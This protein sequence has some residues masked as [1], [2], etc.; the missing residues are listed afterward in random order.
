M[1]ES[2][3]NAETI[4]GWYNHAKSNLS[5]SHPQGTVA[6]VLS[7]S[8]TVN[9]G[10]YIHSP[11]AAAGYGVA[12]SSSSVPSIPASDSTIPAGAS[13]TGSV[14]PYYYVKD[15]VYLYVTR[16]ES[17]PSWVIVPSTY[18]FTMK[19]D[20]AEEMSANGECGREGKKGSIS[21]SQQPSSAEE[22][23]WGGW[24]KRKRNYNV[25]FKIKI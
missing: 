11:V 5:Q 13:Q 8:T 20:G 18:G 4:Q 14:N 22:M 25:D 24:C 6:A 21:A 3:Y 10:T 12:S 9:H 2:D 17:L 1:S 16:K 23:Y 15:K 19:I 7:T